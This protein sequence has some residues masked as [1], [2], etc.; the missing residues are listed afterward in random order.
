MDKQE[1]KRHGLGHSPLGRSSRPAG[2]QCADAVC[3]FGNSRGGPSSANSVD[4]SCGEAVPGSDGVS[5]FDGKTQALP[6][7]HHLSTARS[8]S[9]PA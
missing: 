6:N 3:E 7:I 9:A 4:K 2:N 8:L 1:S 5:H